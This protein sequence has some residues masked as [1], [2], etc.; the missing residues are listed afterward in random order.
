MLKYSTGTKFAENLATKPIYLYTEHAK[1]G[2]FH[3]NIYCVTKVF[4]IFIYTQKKTIK[5]Q[6]LKGFIDVT[7]IIYS[8]AIAFYYLKYFF[9]WSDTVN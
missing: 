6:K 9:H 8:F 3:I 5:P 4:G 1:S 2:W 7:L